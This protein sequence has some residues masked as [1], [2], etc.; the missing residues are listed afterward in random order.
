MRAYWR[1]LKNSEISILFSCF[2]FV[3]LLYFFLET[4]LLNRLINQNT[5]C[6]ISTT[7]IVIQRL[8]SKKWQ[9]SKSGR[10]VDDDRMLILP[11]KCHHHYYQSPP[12]T[13]K[14]G[15]QQY[16]TNAFQLCKQAKGGS[17]VICSS[18]SAL[19]LMVLWS[20][21]STHDSP[22]PTHSNIQNWHFSHHSCTDRGTLLRFDHAIYQDRSD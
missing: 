7:N 14:L 6:T 9:I 18:W 1:S 13:H 20:H 19:N 22:D 4:K 16:T 11:Y 8:H 21:R 3:Y 10:L 12:V 2:G 17:S 15:L 5:W